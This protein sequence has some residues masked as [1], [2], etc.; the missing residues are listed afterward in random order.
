MQALEMTYLQQSIL[1]HIFNLCNHLLQ[2]D[3]TL[4]Q[5]LSEI[6]SPWKTSYLKK[7]KMD[8]CCLT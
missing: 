2:K 5:K 6:V 4:S 8:Y 1:S 7:N 3:V